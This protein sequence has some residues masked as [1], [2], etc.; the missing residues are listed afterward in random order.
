MVKMNTKET[1]VLLFA[2]FL[3]LSCGYAQD[4]IVPAIITFG[5]SAVDVGNNDY[6]P[7]IY[8]ANYPPYGRDFVNKQATGR[9]C[10]GKLATD[11]TG[12]FCIKLRLCVVLGF[13]LCFMFSRVS[14]AENSFLLMFFRLFHARRKCYVS[15]GFS[16]F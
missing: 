2:S 15:E 10:N 11:I 14:S 7:T 8:K 5:D 16:R 9:F 6:L 13:V 3:F 4:T 1:L 12:N